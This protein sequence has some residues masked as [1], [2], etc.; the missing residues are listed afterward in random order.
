MRGDGFLANDVDR[1][2]LAGPA[3][4]ARAATVKGFGLGPAVVERLLDRDGDGLGLLAGQFQ[5]SGDHRGVGALALEQ[6]AEDGVQDVRHFH[7]KG[8]GPRGRLGGGELQ[9]HAQM[10]GQFL[11]V[12]IEPSLLIGLH[13]VDNGRTSVARVA[14]H[15]LEQVQ[16][17]GTAT[18]EGVDVARLHLQRVLA[19]QAGDQRTQFVAAGG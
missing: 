11:G 16:R 6:R 8:L 1:L 18:V 19:L 13:Q 3:L 17:G 10:V 5:H 14:V 2:C 7:Q 12:K 15:M 4:A 9:H